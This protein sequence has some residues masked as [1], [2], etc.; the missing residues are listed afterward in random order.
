MVSHRGQ[1]PVPGGKSQD[2]RMGAWRAERCR[3]KSGSG[4]ESSGRRRFTDAGGNRKGFNL[5]ET[6]KHIGE[7]K[8]QFALGQPKLPWFAAGVLLVLLGIGLDAA[9]LSLLGLAAIVASLLHRISDSDQ[10]N[11]AA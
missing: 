6:L 11:K 10:T 8:F 7:Y 2:G 5:P 9:L 3:R 1:L 4:L